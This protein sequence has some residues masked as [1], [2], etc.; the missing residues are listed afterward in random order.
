MTAL[1][2]NINEMIRNL[3]D[4]TLKN[5]EQDWLKT[6]VAKFPHATGPERSVA[7][8]KLVLSSLRRRV[9]VLTRTLGGNEPRL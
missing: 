2:G 4:T 6:G 8:R 9:T 1:K 3:K 7:A 5:N